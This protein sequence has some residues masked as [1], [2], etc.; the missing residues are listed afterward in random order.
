MVALILATALSFTEVID[1]TVDPNDNVR[2]LGFLVAAAAF[3]SMTATLWLIQKYKVNLTRP[4]LL[5]MITLYLPILS[6]NALI[7]WQDSIDPQLHKIEQRAEAAAVLDIPFDKRKYVDALLD[8]RAERQN[9]FQYTAPAEFIGASYCES[10]LDI[11]GVKTVPIASLASTPVLI[12]NELGTYPIWMTDRY[13]FNNPDSVW[14]DISLFDSII[15]GDSFAAGQS[16]EQGQEIAAQLRKLDHKSLNLASIGAG[17]LNA[18]AQL[19]EYGSSISTNYVFWVFYHGN[20]FADLNHELNH[21]VISRYLDPTFSQ[22]LRANSAIIDPVYREY[23]TKVLTTFGKTRN[24]AGCAEFK[25]VTGL[26][27]R[28]GGFISL[29]TLKNSVARIVDNMRTSPIIS[30]NIS[31]FSFIATLIDNEARQNG[32]QLVFVFMPQYFDLPKYFEP[33]EMGDPLISKDRVFGTITSLGIP[34]IDM[35][36]TINAHSDPASFYPLR[37]W[38]HMSPFGYQQVA[39]ELKQ[40]A[41]ENRR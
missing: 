12:T 21:P 22:N 41:I 8:I 31:E 17:P 1:P 25:P 18:L 34:I 35:Q 36:K 26:R 37:I 30:G 5:V 3:S 11:D 38:G 4:I 2:R 29:V 9:V 32:A 27:R 23:A 15:I 7:T 13:G 28:I 24:G 19:R 14:D 16:V 6:A 10:T 40:Y 33:H 39:S 20:D